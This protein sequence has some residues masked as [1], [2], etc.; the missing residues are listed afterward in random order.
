MPTK[1]EDA[2]SS[3]RLLLIFLRSYAGLNQTELEK[4]SGIHQ[5]MISRYESG[6]SEPSPETVRRVAAAVGVPW[7]VARDLG[8]CFSAVIRRTERRWEKQEIDPG[9]MEAILEPALMA[10]F[11][12]LVEELTA[13][14][15]PPSPEEQRREAEA[16]W[17]N[18]QD[19]PPSRRRRLIELAQGAYPGWAL[20]ERICEASFQTA[21]GAPEEALELADW[22]LSIA[23]KM[24]G[25]A[26]WRSRVEGYC[27]AHLAYARRAAND[28]AGAEEASARAWS[29]WRSGEDAGPGLLLESRVAALAG[30]GAGA[31]LTERIPDPVP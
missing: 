12:Y 30:V 26:G 27:W 10:V 22:A 25:E 13:V 14:P 11:P 5:T 28:A 20:A 31:L 18:L 6:K 21:G 9:L 17:A 19:F 8:R 2:P 1:E 15:E 24:P 16:I 7:P 29:L 4:V 23:A 3:W